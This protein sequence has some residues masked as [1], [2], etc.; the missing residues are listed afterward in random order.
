VCGSPQGAV[1]WK[2]VL[3]CFC[4]VFGGKQMI[5]VLKIAKERWWN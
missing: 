4:G 3:S 1:V 5:E 2:M